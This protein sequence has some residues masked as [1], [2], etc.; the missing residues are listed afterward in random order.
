MQAKEG[1]I[2]ELQEQIANAGGW[3]YKVHKERLAEFQAA[4]ENVRSVVDA[5]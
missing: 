3:D 1:R 4:A 2:A 5:N